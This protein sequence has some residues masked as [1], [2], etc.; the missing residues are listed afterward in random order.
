MNTPSIP[1]KPSLLASLQAWLT[2]TYGDSLL[3]TFE[4]AKPFHRLR[5]EWHK[6]FLL[7]DA[8]LPWIRNEI[9]ISS[10]Y[11]DELRANTRPLGLVRILIRKREKGDEPLSPGRR[12][13]ARSVS[14]SPIN[15][16]TK[17]R[18]SRSNRRKL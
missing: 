7:R 5:P 9:G 13:R 17:P 1:R 6:R 4:P 12:A 2:R 18:D 8:L 10:F 3:E 14:K 11:P 15:L 16:A